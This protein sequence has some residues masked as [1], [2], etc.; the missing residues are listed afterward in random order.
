MLRRNL[1]NYKLLRISLSGFLHRWYFFYVFRGS[2]KSNP[3]KTFPS[4]LFPKLSF[5]DKHLIKT[6]YWLSIPYR[7]DNSL[8][9][10][11]SLPVYRKNAVFM[12]WDN[13]K[14]VSYFQKLFL[15]LLTFRCLY[16]VLSNSKILSK[17]GTKWGSR[18]NFA[19]VNPFEK[20]SCSMI[21]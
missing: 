17:K 4:C 13:N 5:G 8:I 21:G 6:K 18:H 14:A 9:S 7:V 1:S 11:P 19:S 15:L 20:E 10:F 16:F 12:I 3:L 2:V